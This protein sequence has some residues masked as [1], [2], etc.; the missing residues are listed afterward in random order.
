MSVSTITGTSFNPVTPVCLPHLTVQHQRSKQTYNTIGFQLQVSQVTA[1]IKEVISA[2][3]G[4]R[5][6]TMYSKSLSQTPGVFQSPLEAQSYQHPQRRRWACRQPP[7]LVWWYPLYKA[8]AWSKQV[9]AMV[10]TTIIS[11]KGTSS[12]FLQ[13][14]T[15]GLRAKFKLP[16][17]HEVCS[18]TC[19]EEPNDF[20]PQLTKDCHWAVRGH[21]SIRTLGPVSNQFLILPTPRKK[22]VWRK[23]LQLQQAANEE[24]WF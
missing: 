5:K 19:A 2:E 16:S 9:L 17:Q 15:P 3:A 12:L 23:R 6:S 18:S 4:E 20:T 11:P 13:N 1:K 24:Y 8:F 10:E 7:L 14:K 21:L 22:D